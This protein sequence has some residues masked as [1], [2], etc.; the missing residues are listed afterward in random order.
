MTK[1]KKN[2]ISWLQL[3]DLHIRQ[4]TDW[5][6][7]QE[8]Y[9][10]LAEK[11]NPQFIVLTGDYKHKKY[12]ENSKYEKTKEFLSMIKG[13]FGL[14]EEDFFFVPGN[15]D[16]EDYEFRKESIQTIVKSVEE[17]AD[18]YKEY[19]YPSKKLEGSL[20]CAFQQYDQ[21]IKNFY[22]GSITDGRN[23][24]PSGVNCYTW[25]NMLNVIMLN[26]ALI[27]DGDR[28]HK[29]IV[30]IQSFA[31]LIIDTSKPS[32]VLAH[33]DFESLYESHKE[34]MRTIFDIKNVKA[35]L[36]GDV[37][38][39]TVRY[40]NKYNIHNQ[41]VP[42][43]VCGKSAVE[44]GDSH[45][46]VTAIYYEWR[47]DGCVYVLP[48]EWNGKFFKKS[49]EF[50]DEED[51]DFNFFVGN[52]DVNEPK[53]IQ[54][55]NCKEDVCL[56]GC[57]L[58]VGK[59]TEKVYIKDIYFGTVD[60]DNEIK[61][62]PDKFVNNYFDLSNVSSD[63]LK[64]NNIQFVV[65]RKGTGKTY[66]GMY[67]QQTLGGTVKYLAMDSFDYKALNFLAS[68]GDGYEPY[69]KPWKYFILAQCLIYINSIIDN[70]EMKELLFE[71]Y[72]RKATIEQILNKKFKKGVWFD[73]EALSQKWKKELAKE[74]ECFSLVEITQI[75]SMMLEEHISQK[76][77]LIL[78]GL[79]EKINE[80]KNYSD[81]MNGLIWAVKNINAEM[82]NERLELKVVVFFRKDVFDFVQG[83]NTA[84]SAVGSTINLDWVSDSEDKKK[85]PLYQF[86][87]RRYRNCLE[88]QGIESEMFE[89]ESLFPQTVKVNNED[90]DT[91][92][93]I[94][95]FT[96]YK[97]RD[98]VKMLSECGKRCV[99][100]E[101][102]IS[103]KI[104]WE[105]MPEYSNYIAKELKN[106]LYG[107]V[108]EKLINS[109]FGKLQSM[110]KAWKNYQFVKGIIIKSCH[111]VGLEL[112]DE[113]INNT[114]NKM[115]EA[116]ILGVQ[117]PNE[118][119][120]WYYRK[121]IKINDYIE[122]SKYRVHMGLWKEL[123]IW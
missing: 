97:P 2:C 119:E 74:N 100:N 117:L 91:W 118:H 10:K 63:L 72:G 26:S 51:Q 90:V 81:M 96:T 23:E 75:F 19:Q 103:Q 24:R 101:T 47:N 111:S 112:T 122:C 89:L 29:E 77:V 11:I 69:V 14:Q 27:S 37:H 106:E 21:F 8:K 79:D 48:Y 42:C 16:V 93:W 6:I 46:D 59:E 83:A 60:A 1:E 38:K 52:F 82:Y 62:E 61:E 20:E 84:K 102:N 105:A 57:T 114:I 30:D 108:D 12:S 34:R 44:Q 5:S 113:E 92:E 54:E 25:K 33:H 73:E 87:N 98:I 66:T 9:K 35:Y 121:Y 15:H 56:E 53:D 40:I 115:Y 31:D 65:G 22:N 123:S 13:I 64:K 43:I 58:I 49:T 39:D 70:E 116:G 99:N 36:C 104:I 95:N 78:D 76:Y 80:H 4:S 94:L 7:M 107:F 17:K 109:I 88:E 71:L 55:I 41:L 67:L 120:Q 32:I 50:V 68:D 3:S 86:M 18:I 85:Y 110:G 28:K 45:S